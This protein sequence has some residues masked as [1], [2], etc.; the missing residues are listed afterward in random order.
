MRLKY[1]LNT[2][3]I[4]LKTNRTRSALTILG[5]VIGIAAIILIM[6]LGKGAQDLIL[7]EIQS[8]GPK[9]IAI[10]PGREP[11][12]PTDIISTFSDSLKNKD[13]EALGRKENAPH[14][15]KIMPIIFGGETA[16]FGNETYRMTI[17]GVTDLFTEIYGIYPGEG[18]IFGDDE[19]KSYSSVVIIGSKIKDELFGDSDAM[20]QKIRIKERNY[21]VIGVLP[22]QGQSGFLNFD[23]A[24]I[25]PY[26]TAQTYI[27]GI[28]HFHRIVVEADSE[29][30]VDSTVEDIEATLRSSHN[31]TDPSKDDFF[32]QTQAQA[33]DTV[34]AIT[35]VLTLFLTSVAAIS[36]VV[37]GIGIMNIML[38]SV[39]ERTREIGLRKAIGATNKNILNQFLLEA[40]LLTA[41]GG[42]I[43]VT[44]GTIMSFLIS[45]VLSRFAGLDW[46]FTFP[47]S[48]AII[49]FVVSASIGLIFGLYPAKKASRKN[50]IDALRYE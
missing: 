42:I 41:M 24:A 12:G 1:V 25:I 21:R 14:I 48:G 9:T 28:K 36:L 49:G 29:A 20:N 31:I 32:V 8:I 15:A 19:I 43:G 46:T 22:K 34:S 47:V 16:S 7:S 18:R 30:N 38:V 23:D 10:I 44:I 35:S 17:F 26:T 27:F 4:G 2:A 13:I 37:G 40:V 3:I 33:L 6:S 45:I 39:T 50:P 11:K 5:I